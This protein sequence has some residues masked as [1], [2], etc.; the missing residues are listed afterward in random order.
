MATALDFRTNNGGIRVLFFSDHIPQSNLGRVE[1]QFLGGQVHEPLHGQHPNRQPH[2]AVHSNSGLVGG[3]RH[4]LKAKGRG[5]IRSGHAGGGV[6]GFKGRP[7]GVF[8]IRAHIADKPTPDA[9]DGSVLPDGKF[10]LDGL[11]FG[12]E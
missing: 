11:L 6:A 1:S 2:P 8:G 10:G 7:P 3:N 4:G 5:L 9:E 12:V